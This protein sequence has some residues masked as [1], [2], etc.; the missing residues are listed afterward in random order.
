LSI[1]RS[2]G[3]T[4]AIGE[5]IAPHGQ[6][7]QFKAHKCPTCNGDHWAREDEIRET[8][9]ADEAKTLVFGDRQNAY[10]HPLDDYTATAGMVNA[11][12]AHKLKEGFTAEEMMLI[13]AIVKV[14]RLSRNMTHRDSLVDVSGYSLCIEESFKERERRS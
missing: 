3:P 2:V 9:V 1:A 5:P 13:M 7:T 14:S 10:H 12:F 11:A 4:D 6:T 8:T